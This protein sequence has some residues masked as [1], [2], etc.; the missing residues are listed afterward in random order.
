[1]RMLTPWRIRIVVLALAAM[2]LTARSSSAQK[3]ADPAAA[4]N[5][6]ELLVCDYL[7]RELYRIDRSGTIVWKHRPPGL[8]WDFVVTPDN[9]VVYPTLDSTQEVR[10]IDFDA[11]VKWTWSYRDEYREIINLTR[12]DN[13][14]LV[15]GQAPPQ[16]VFMNLRGEIARRLP[17][18]ARYTSYHGQ[19]GNVYD[20]G[21][22]RYLAQLWGDG[23][24][25]EIDD[26]G[27]ETWRFDVPRHGSGPYPQTTVQDVLR[28]KNGNTL[29][30][31]GTQARLLEVDPAGKIVWQFTRD[32]R[33]ELNFTNACNLQLLK[34]G[35]ILVT[36]FLRGSTGRGAHAFILSDSREI[37]WTL[38]DHRQL[39]ALSQAW[40]FEN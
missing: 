8:V 14:I 18:P 22:G 33:P 36:N 35:S 23:A 30:A 6:F 27:K 29:I 16:V 38:T 31:C 28:L 2:L 9:H 24:A 19:L 40:A 5:P 3:P 25:L 39:Q 13:L 10:C 17:I 34:D 15:S 37:T 20:V 12:R 26:N 7:A 21:N 32:D 1:M 11:R 4:Q